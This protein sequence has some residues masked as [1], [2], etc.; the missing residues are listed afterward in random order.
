MCHSMSRGSSGSQIA[1]RRPEQQAQTGTPTK[2]P[3]ERGRHRRGRDVQVRPVVWDGTR[4]RWENESRR[5]HV[6]G[7]IHARLARP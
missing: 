7:P 4:I 2:R 6:G 1:R 5:A 3:V